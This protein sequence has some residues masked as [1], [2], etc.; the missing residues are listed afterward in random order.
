MNTPPQRQMHQNYWIWS[1]NLTGQAIETAAI[2]I[3]EKP[4]LW[5]LYSDL[6]YVQKISILAHVE[7]HNCY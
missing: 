5:R 4:Y 2:N 1:D 7:I 6:I 3:N